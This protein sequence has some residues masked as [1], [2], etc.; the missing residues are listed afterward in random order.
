MAITFTELAAV[1]STANTNSYA[2]GS[3]SPGA[4]RLILVAVGLSDG[5]GAD[6]DTPTSVTGNGITYELVDATEGNNLYLTGQTINY[7]VLLYRGMSASP[8]A[9]AVTVAFTN[10]ATGCNIVVVEADGVDTSGTNGSGAIVQAKK[11]TAVGTALTVTLTSAPDAANAVYATYDYTNAV[12]FTPEGT[13]TELPATEIT[14][15][16]PGHGMGGQY[17][18]GADQTAAGT[19]GSSAEIGGIAVEVAAAGG[20]TAYE[21]DAQPGS[22]AVTGSVAGPVAGRTVNAAPGSYTVTGA[23]ASVPAGRMIS[24]SPG[25]YSVTGAA[26]ALLADRMLNAASGSFTVTGVEAGL[27][28]EPLGGAFELDAQPGSFTISGAAASPVAGRVIVGSPGSY[29]LT[30][31]QAGALAGRALAADPGAFSVAGVAAS[32]L[33][34]RLVVAAPGGYVITGFSATLL[35]GEFAD[36]PATRRTRV[37]LG[38]SATGPGIASGRTSAGLA[39]GRTSA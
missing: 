29:T 13:W 33:A 35:G 20:V 9:G 3:I 39:F 22:F 32:P 24:A 34:A 16:N 7:R 37:T 28:Y 36:P 23:A 14:H 15:A 30:G 26:A 38:R 10:S 5:G 8:S 25:A 12:T 19:I 4:N 6:P 27:V 1:A 11:N 17:I 21:I 31:S 2:T 18:V